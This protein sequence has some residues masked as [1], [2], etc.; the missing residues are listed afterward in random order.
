MKAPRPRHS[1]VI[2]KFYPPHLG[3]VHLASMAARFSDHV[4][5]VVM[6][7]CAEN[8][9]IQDRVDW[10]S[11]ALAHF[12]GLRVTGIVDDLPV[13]YADPDAWDGHVELMR[14][15]VELADQPHAFPPLDAV[16]SSEFYGFEMGERLGVLPVVLDPQ[17]TTLPA[18]GMAVRRDLVGHW[19]FLP[20][21][22]CAG[23]C[24][25]V[26]IVGAEST[27]TTTLASDLAAF[28]KTRGGA[29]ERTQ[30]VAEYG[31]DHSA[32]MV[33]LAASLGDQ[34][35]P[36]D[37]EWSEEDFLF[38]AQEQTR[39]ENEAAR[40]GGPVLVMDTDALATTIWHER[41]R[42]KHSER[43]TALVDA[44]PRRDLYVLTDHEGVLFHQDGL[45]DGE[46]LR[47]AMTQSFDALLGSQSKV[48]WIRVKGDRQSR[49][50]QVV[51]CIDEILAVRF[52]FSAPL[53][54]ANKPLGKIQKDSP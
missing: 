10:L 6:G 49:I 33:S 30:W 9:S 7:S 21:A 52:A 31:R 1:L 35:M 5:V 19:D 50:D 4:T 43:L 34:G 2:G 51:R 44:L 48:P 16:F 54:Q 17:R 41:Y 13:D 14:K 8:L 25:R 32:T 26:V 18:S 42:G 11:D 12:P 37:L 39:Q 23:L 45:R 53:P 24:L 38:I 40:R 20:A 22:T 15:A 47:E 29:W 36:E 46:H 28:L 3:H 27:G